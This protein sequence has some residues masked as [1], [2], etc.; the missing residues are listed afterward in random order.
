MVELKVVA[1][2]SY[3]ALVLVEGVFGQTRFGF[4]LFWSSS[5]MTLKPVS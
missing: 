4:G 5:R 3:K 1:I 2:C